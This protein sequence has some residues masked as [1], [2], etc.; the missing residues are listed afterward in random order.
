MTT[1]ASAANLLQAVKY[2]FE[3]EPTLPSF[4][5]ST[6]AVLSR[7]DNSAGQASTQNALES[8]A[9]AVR[10]PPM[11]MGAVDHFLDVFIHDRWPLALARRR[12]GWDPSREH[13]PS[14]SWTFPRPGH[15]DDPVS[16]PDFDDFLTQAGQ[17]PVHS[18]KGP[19]FPRA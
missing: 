7:A 17:Q 15:L 5:S 12:R 9:F 11:L 10:A 16:R 6:C 14:H 1:V 13:F 19:H 18:S 3:L 8:S 4:V 2:D